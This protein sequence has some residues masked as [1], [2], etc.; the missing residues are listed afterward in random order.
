MSF[1]TWF[2]GTA[3]KSE[4]VEAGQE[5][6]LVA[7][8]DGNPLA[9]HVHPVYPLVIDPVLVGATE[10]FSVLRT[11]LLNAHHK[12][13]LRSLIVTSPEKEEGKSLICTNL[14]ITLGQLGKPR[15]LLVDGD[16]R[17]RGMT[18][19]LALQD[20]RGVGDYL[21]DKAEFQDCIRSTEYP[22]LCIAPV[23][24]VQ[25]DSMPT[26]L[27]GPRWPA[28]LQRAKEEFDLIIVDSVPITAPIADF[29][30]LSGPCDAALLTVQ[31]RKTTREALDLTV[32]RL[33]KRLIGVI[34]N[35]AQAGSG[36]YAD[37]YGKKNPYYGKSKRKNGA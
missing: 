7:E 3:E 31:L 16:L 30:L 4:D 17:V 34:I 9:F 36:Y 10:H 20:H 33:E 24:D 19:L 2:N 27:E 21:Q 1:A 29:E 28:F 22:S 13:G 23:G 11:R 26:L 6:Q 14:G 32:S 18:E 35:N 25:E 5:P 8:R 12:T 15:V 37:Y